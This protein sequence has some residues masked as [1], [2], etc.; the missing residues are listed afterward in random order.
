[1]A[2]PVNATRNEFEMILKDE[3]L[4]DHLK[5]GSLSVTDRDGQLMS[6]GPD[7]VVVRLNN[8]HKT[9][10]SFLHVAVYLALLFGA[11]L[12]S[13]VVGLVKMFVR[14]NANRSEDRTP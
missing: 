12:M 11:S 4:Q 9:K 14:R 13:L 7:D 5:R 6:V 1:M 2:L 3:L 10:A 8:W